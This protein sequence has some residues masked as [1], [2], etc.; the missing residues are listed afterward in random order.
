MGQAGGGFSWYYEGFLVIRQ[1]YFMSGMER[2]RTIKR[3]LVS[4]LEAFRV[5]RGHLLN[6]NE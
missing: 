1:T 5:V 2:L 4:S 6:E 3:F